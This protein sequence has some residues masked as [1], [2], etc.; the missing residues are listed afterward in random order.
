MSDKVA[1]AKLVVNFTAGAGVSK[2]VND[3]IKNNTTVEST[4]D[5]VKV[6]AGSIVI[7]SMAADAGSKHVNAKM[8]AIAAWWDS[9]KTDNTTTE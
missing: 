3:I 1:I 8:D 4:T 2:I 9:R 6:W 7:G 5:A